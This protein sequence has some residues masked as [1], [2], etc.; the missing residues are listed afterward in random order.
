MFAENRAD[1]DCAFRFLRVARR[2]QVRLDYR[3][4]CAYRV[5]RK[6]KLWQKFFPDLEVFPHDVEG[7]HDASV[8]DF[9]GQFTLA[10]QFFG[11]FCR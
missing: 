3:E 9:N 1:D 4:T 8:D 11:R 5:R 6:Q 7:W 10:E 2:L